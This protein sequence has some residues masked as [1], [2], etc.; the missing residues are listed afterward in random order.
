VLAITSNAAEAIRRILAEAGYDETAGL[1]VGLNRI[2]DDKVSLQLLAAQE[3]AKGD[4]V[5]DYEGIRL[6]ID[7]QAYTTL[8][9]RILDARVS[10]QGI[11][12]TMGRQEGA[13][14]AEA[15]MW[16]KG[17]SYVKA[18][19]IDPIKRGRSMRAKLQERQQRMAVD[20]ARALIKW[21]EG[22]GADY[23]DEI[24][25]DRMDLVASLWSTSKNRGRS[26]TK[27]RPSSSSFF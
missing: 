15:D 12:F 17:S 19:S 3:P 27:D 9:D 11:G 25:A 26:F 16:A 23:P 18:A 1:R 10:D 6:F 5:I 8:D 22:Q 7:P 24:L 2:T 20:S 4:H 21:F 14:A 13:A